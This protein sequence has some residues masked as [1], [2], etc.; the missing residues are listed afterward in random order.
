MMLQIKV[1]WDEVP[2]QL[3]ITKVVEELMLP[4]S[5]QSKRRGLLDPQPWIAMKREARSSSK[6]SLTI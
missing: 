4:S 2:C 1:F 6:E 3:A 5:E